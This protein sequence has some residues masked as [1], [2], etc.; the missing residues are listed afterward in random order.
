M[1]ERDLRKV[2]RVTAGARLAQRWRVGYTQHGAVTRTPGG[3]AETMKQLEVKLVRGFMRVFERRL[4]AALTVRLAGAACRGWGLDPAAAADPW[5]AARLARFALLVP[6]AMLPEGARLEAELL[7]ERAALASSRFGAL[8]RLFW[9]QPPRLVRVDRQGWWSAVRTFGTPMPATLYGPALLE[10]LLPDEGASRG[11][12]VVLG[13]AG[14]A[15]GGRVELA[16]ARWP[17]VSVPSVTLSVAA[18]ELRAALGAEDGAQSRRAWGSVMTPAL[19]LGGERARHEAALAAA[20]GLE[21]GVAQRVQQVFEA[22]PHL[23]DEALSCGDR[24]ALARYLVGLTSLLEP[25]QHLAERPLPQ[26]LG[27]SRRGYHVRQALYHLARVPERLPD[28]P[29]ARV[30]WIDSPRNPRALIARANTSEDM[31]PLVRAARVARHVVLDARD[32]PRAPLLEEALPLA[33]V[34]AGYGC[35][36]DGT[37]PRAP[38]AELLARPLSRLRLEP[39]HAVFASLA[40]TVAIGVAL[41]ASDEPSLRDAWQQYRSEQRWLATWPAT[42]D[43][44]LAGARAPGDVYDELVRGVREVFSPALG[45]QPLEV[46]GVR[47]AV[48]ARLCAALE[49]RDEGARLAELPASSATLLRAPGVGES[50]LRELVAALFEHLHSWRGAAPTDGVS[51]AEPEEVRDG[52]AELAALFGPGES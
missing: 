13:W 25:S 50:T 32:D 38:E 27:G 44:A 35:H 6:E 24:E 3:G 43:E 8:V 9:A 7:E 51:M 17:L 28:E 45:A 37:M 14:A 1:S 48:H 19:S 11:H 42:L 40:P 2:C 36:L 34:L 46:L 30:E 29:G 52:F 23:L 15:D 39:T 31:A 20:F 5:S 21:A 18:H 10:P 16:L 33:M 41:R 22:L 47:K 49:A 4:D 12:E 26:A